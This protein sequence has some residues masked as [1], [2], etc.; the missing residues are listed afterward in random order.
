MEKFFINIEKLDALKKAY[1][2]LAFKY[3][4][5]RGGSET[6]MKEI[7]AEYVII[8][9]ALKKT[10]ERQA[11]EDSDKKNN[12]Q[13]Y[14]ERFDLDDGFREMIDKVIGLD[15][16]VI[17]IIGYWIW[18][19]GET[20]RNKE[21]LR[22]AGFRYSGQKAAWYW[23]PEGLQYRSGHTLKDLNSVRDKYGSQVVCDE[24]PIKKRYLKRA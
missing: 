19:T 3:H 6:I 22:V 12:Q 9:E 13:N 10:A 24:A 15:G 5:D 14:T 21:A 7:N 17:E 20:K 4:P 8:F 1:R 18:I 2:Q 23:R 16:I 11:A